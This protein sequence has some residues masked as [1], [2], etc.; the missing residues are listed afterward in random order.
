MSKKSTLIKGL[1]KCVN[2]VSKKSVL[3]KGPKVSLIQDV[4]KGLKFA[5]I[6]YL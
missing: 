5:L 4:K 3:I 2:Q 1:K 6:K